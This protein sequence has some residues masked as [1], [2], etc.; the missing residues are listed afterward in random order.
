MQNIYFFYEIEH[1]KL[2]TIDFRLYMLWL[3]FRLTK[4][5]NWFE[6]CGFTLRPQDA[7][8]IRSHKKFEFGFDFS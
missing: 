3:S 4:L 2:K 7:S 1:K 8:D 5:V 6:K